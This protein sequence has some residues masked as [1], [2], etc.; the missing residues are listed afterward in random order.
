MLVYQRVMRLN[1]RICRFLQEKIGSLMRYMAICTGTLMEC[2]G[3]ILTVVDK[4][5]TFLKIS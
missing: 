1:G 4:P 5:G 3:T 2:N